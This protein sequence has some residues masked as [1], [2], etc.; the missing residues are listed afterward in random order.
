ME[1]PAHIA[2]VRLQ[3][4]ALLNYLDDLITEEEPFD[5]AS[6]AI[7]CDEAELDLRKLELARIQA[8]DKPL[9]DGDPIGLIPNSVTAG[10]G[11]LALITETSV[12]KDAGKK[13]GD[14]WSATKEKVKR[15]LYPP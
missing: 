6:F 9:E 15:W 13:I 7:Q 14:W 3:D 12:V 5:E 1:S 4:A 8:Y 2:N 10:A 11:A